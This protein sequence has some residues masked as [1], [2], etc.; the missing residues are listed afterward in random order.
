[1]TEFFKDPLIRTLWSIV[2][3]LLTEDQIF[4]DLTTV[5]EERRRR[6]Q[7]TMKEI[8]RVL[9]QEFSLELPRWWQANYPQERKLRRAK[10]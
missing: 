9:S 7:E 2:V 3:G 1:M 8:T 4:C 6:K 5:S 10:N